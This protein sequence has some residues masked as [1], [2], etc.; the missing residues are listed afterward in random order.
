M[1]SSRIAKRLRPWAVFGIGMLLCARIGHAEMTAHN[2]AHALRRV[3]ARVTARKGAAHH[4]VPRA[5]IARAVE[6]RLLAR[7]AIRDRGP[8]QRTDGLVGD[9]KAVYRRPENYATDIQMPR[10]VDRRYAPA[11]QYLWCVPYARDV[12]HIDL[13]GD[14]FLWWAE[15]AGRYAR[16]IRPSRGAVLVFRSSSRIR[17]GHV[18]VV[19][20]VLNSREILVD[21]ANWLPDR[22]SLDVPVIDVSPENNW[23][24]VRVALGNG[25]FGALYPTY[26]FIYDRAPG[27]LTV[28]DRSARTEVAMA[29]SVHPIRLTAPYRQLR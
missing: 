4:W 19:E 23:S 25:G 12:S 2:Y 18:A 17:L 14:A 10:A 29:P 3:T 11:G 6:H 8:R 24:E 20:A 5:H 28:A 13:V 16:G 22:V 1:A 7:V 15:A 9:R 27:T 21:Q 26:G